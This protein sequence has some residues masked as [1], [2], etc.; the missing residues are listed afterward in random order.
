MVVADKG[1]GIIPQDALF[2]LTNQ[3][4]GSASKYLVFRPFGKNRRHKGY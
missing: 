2:N 1:G 4:N 3:T